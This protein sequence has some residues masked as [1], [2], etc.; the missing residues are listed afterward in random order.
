MIGTSILPLGAKNAAGRVP[1]IQ[2]GKLHN[3]A[4]VGG[5][6]DHHS[7]VQADLRRA[8]KVDDLTGSGLFDPPVH[9]RAAAGRIVRE[10][11]LFEGRAVGA[12]SGAAERLEGR[13]TDGAP[14]AVG[15]PELLRRS[16]LFKA[17]SAPRAFAVRV[18]A[19]ERPK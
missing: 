8:D 13:V 14:E 16:V 6:R 11:E 1:S 19:R 17:P 9:D 4:Q 7:G 10:V 2:N 12:R 3:R 5:V 18:A 15:D